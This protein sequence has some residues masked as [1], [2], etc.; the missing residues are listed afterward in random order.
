MKGMAM[1]K[2]KVSV[3]GTDA[4]TKLA[5]AAQAKLVESRV[6]QILETARARGL[7]QHKSQGLER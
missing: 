2:V 1:D 4:T 6:R 5:P 3:K 7:A